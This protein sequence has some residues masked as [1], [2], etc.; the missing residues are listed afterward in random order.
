MFKKSE[1]D[2]KLDEEIL[3]VLNLIRAEDATTDGYSTLVDRLTT[4]HGLRE[5][6]RISKDTLA[7]IVANVVGI[8]IILGH[9]RTNVIASKAFGL[10]KKI[11]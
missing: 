6:N 2:T 4:L 9:E 10:V 1:I 5:K 7:T 3:C 8:A 11:F